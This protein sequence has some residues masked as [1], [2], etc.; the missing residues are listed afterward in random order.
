MH[1]RTPTPA[2][3]A[4]AAGKKRPGISK[5]STIEINAELDNSLPSTTGIATAANPDRIAPLGGQALAVAADQELIN[6][7]P[8]NRTATHAPLV[9]IKPAGE[10]N[11]A[12]HAHGATIQINLEPISARSVLLDPIAQTKQRRLFSAQLDISLLQGKLL[13]FNVLLVCIQ[14][15]ER[16]PAS[17][18]LLASN[19]IQKQGL[20]IPAT[21]AT[22]LQRET[23]IVINVQPVAIHRQVLEFAPCVQKMN[24]LR[25]ARVIACRALQERSRLKAQ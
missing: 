9:S 16:R 20:R 2:R 17:L 5:R 1:W 19:A 10:V 13:A 14:A 12:A 4:T 6:H 15:M 25:K 3:L 22:I 8:G 18:V 11:H 23:M 24:S 21:L 7:L